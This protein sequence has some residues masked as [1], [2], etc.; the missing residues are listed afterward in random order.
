MPADPDAVHATTRKGRTPLHYAHTA[1]IAD[2][3]LDHGAD[4]DSRDTDRNGS[5]AQWALFHSHAGQRDWRELAQHYVDRGAEADFLLLCALDDRERI[6]ARLADDPTLVSRRFDFSDAPHAYH[7][8]KMGWWRDSPIDATQ[9]ALNYDRHGL[10]RVLIEAG[11]EFTL[12]HWSMLFP[13]GSRGLDAHLAVL[14]ASGV[15]IDAP[16]ASLDSETMPPLLHCARSEGLQTREHLIDALGAQLL[17]L[18]RRGA[19]P[20]VRD[21]A[22]RTA[23]HHAAANPYGR[24]AIPTLIQHGGEIHARDT[25]GATP[26]D[27]AVERGWEDN[28]HVL[29]GLTA[30]G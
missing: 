23:L 4:I 8:A 14:V 21:S 11:G 5:P 13:K 27:Y 3:L 25:A 1:D 6:E 20:G 7:L 17:V 29:T 26:L 9:A 16:A 12:E 28:V 2:F 15:N 22:G 10:L 19:D 24:D 30:V 18:L